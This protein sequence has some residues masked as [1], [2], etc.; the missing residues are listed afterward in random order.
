MTETIALVIA[1]IVIFIAIVLVRRYRPGQFS[2]RVESVIR[3]AACLLAAIIA[4]AEWGRPESGLPL[5]LTILASAAL[6]YS[7]SHLADR[8][9]V[10]G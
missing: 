1:A 3:I 5:F 4:H 9:F 10:K 6:I 7:A 2:P 8:L